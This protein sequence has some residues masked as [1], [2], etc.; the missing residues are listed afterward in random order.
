ME[1]CVKPVFSF[2]LAGQLVFSSDSLKLPI[3]RMGR[4]YLNRDFYSGII[5]TAGLKLSVKASAVFIKIFCVAKFF[6]SGFM[7]VK[8][9]PGA[10]PNGHGGLAITEVIYFLRHVLRLYMFAI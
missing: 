2:N 1:K 5:E 4:Y 3:M 6:L 10:L 7:I 8:P 9:A